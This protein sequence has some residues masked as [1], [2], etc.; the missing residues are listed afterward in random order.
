MFQEI[1]KKENEKIKLREP[2]LNDLSSQIQAYANHTSNGRG[3]N[4]QF[5]KK[6]HLSAC[7]KSRVALASCILIVCAGGLS[8]K[9]IFQPN[10]AN[11]PQVVKNDGDLGRSIDIPPTDEETSVSLNLFEAHP[12]VKTEST[13]LNQ[14]ITEFKNTNRSLTTLSIDY[15]DQN[16]LIFHNHDQLVVYDMEQASII[17]ILDLTRL[18]AFITKDEQEQ[19]EPIVYEGGN[20]ILFK[21]QSIDHNQDTNCYIYDIATDV[22]YPLTYDALNAIKQPKIV[23]MNSANKHYVDSIFTDG[24][25]STDAVNVNDSIIAVLYYKESKDTTYRSLNLLIQDTS[26]KPENTQSLPIFK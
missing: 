4:P 16:R 6:I 21:N 7:L 24:E 14:Q 1:Y 22:I 12:F 10:I 13:L 23:T 2:F 18:Q 15:V 20:Y 25:R 26:E 9:A 11:T 19:I 8:I 5:S 3:I 17:R